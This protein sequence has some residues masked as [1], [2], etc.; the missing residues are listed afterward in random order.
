MVV[1]GVEVDP[2]EVGQPS[3]TLRTRQEHVRERPSVRRGPTWAVCSEGV[4]A[5]HRGGDAFAARLDDQ[6]CLGEEFDL[7]ALI[8]TPGPHTRGN[9]QAWQHVRASAVFSAISEG[10]PSISPDDSFY[11]T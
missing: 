2:E 4:F 8:I 1:L 3:S 11:P 7:G 9:S 10:R 6:P 5:T